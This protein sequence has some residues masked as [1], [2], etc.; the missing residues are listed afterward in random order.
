MMTEG[1]LWSQAAAE[2]V[3]KN[4]PY[5]RKIKEVI[6]AGGNHPYRSD[7]VMMEMFLK[8]RTLQ[9]EEIRDDL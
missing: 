5:T 2:T 6:D 8:P 4:K 9:A 7:E 1:L 3:G